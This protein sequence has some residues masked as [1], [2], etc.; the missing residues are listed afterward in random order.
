M[1]QLQ[2]NPAATV[3]AL[4]DAFTS[5]D[6]T[7][8]ITLQINTSGSW[9]NMLTFAPERRAQVLRALRVFAGV[10]GDRVRWCLLY[11]DGK[12]EWLDGMQH[13]PWQPV[14][15]DQP[16]AL[17][18]VMVSAYHPSD[19]EPHT[20]MAWRTGNL[21]RNDE[22]LISGSDCEALRMKVYAWAPIIDPMQIPAPVVP[23]PMPADDVGGV[24]SGANRTTSGWIGQP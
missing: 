5:A 8:S 21:A 3:D 15:A 2:A 12:R 18:D 7:P 16:P 17:Q 14:T 24:V 10:L 9:K 20:F 4:F 1:S 6:T 23:T 11:A 13:G 22:W 19:N